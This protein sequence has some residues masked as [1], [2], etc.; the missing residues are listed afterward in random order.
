M[1]RNQGA[2]IGLIVALAPSGHSYRHLPASK[3]RAA[4][5]SLW[6][7]VAINVAASAF[8]GLPPPCSLS[9]TALPL[10]LFRCRLSTPFQP[11][12]ESLPNRTI[13]GHR[14][15]ERPPGVRS[16]P[17]GGHLPAQNICLLWV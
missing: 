10:N 13:C 2:T 4:Y 3:L 11:S 12:L 15:I 6:R 14:L 5:V 8:R 1:C 17:E 9:K 7:F 16:L